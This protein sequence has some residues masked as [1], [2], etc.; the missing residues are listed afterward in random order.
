MNKIEINCVKILYKNLIGDSIMKRQGFTL[1]ELLV[2]ISIIAILM[3]IMMPALRKAR[4]SARMAI[5]A[6]RQKT[7]LT[8]LNIYSS[9]NGG[10][11]T[12]SVQGREYVRNPGVAYWWTIPNRI[13]YYY[14]SGGLNGGAVTEI[15]DS[16]MNDPIYFSC[17]LTGNDVE[18]QKKFMDDYSDDSVRFL[19]TSYLLWWNYKRFASE[20]PKTDEG[21]VKPLNTFNPTAGGDTLM[22]T[23]VL[24]WGANYGQPYGGPNWVSSHP[25]KG[26]SLKNWI[27]AEVRD[28][29]TYFHMLLDP[30]G[31]LVDQYYNSGY[32]DGHVEKFNAKND[33]E[34]IYGGYVLPVKRK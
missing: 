3:S 2:V 4:E 23:D 8:A 18:W 22:I 10:K 14:R 5:C 29:P 28:E 6:N 24:M 9:D 33:Y 13:K 21:Q 16:Y 30:D 15:L 34:W 11:M 12:P 31:N 32:L 27:D 7:I 19:N 26:S 20:E 17:P 25:F 1:I